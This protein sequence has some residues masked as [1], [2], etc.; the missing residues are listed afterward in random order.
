M[1][2]VNGTFRANPDYELV[3]LDRLSG[4]ERKLLDALDVEDLYGVCGPRA[5]A[6]AE[7][8]AATAETALCS[9]R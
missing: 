8:R 6:D 9:S 1:S 7:P 2:F 4:A 3:L 5:G